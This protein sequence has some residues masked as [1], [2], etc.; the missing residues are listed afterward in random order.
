M[1]LEDLAK[2]SGCVA[3]CYPCNSKYNYYPK[4][5]KAENSKLFSL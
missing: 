2:P 1:Q 3:N 5:T 4:R